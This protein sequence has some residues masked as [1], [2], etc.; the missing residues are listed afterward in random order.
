MSGYDRLENLEVQ[1]GNIKRTEQWHAEAFARATH[2]LGNVIAEHAVQRARSRYT[3][4]EYLEAEMLTLNSMLE[5]HREASARAHQEL[6]KVT[7]EYKDQIIERDY[8]E[9]TQYSRYGNSG[10]YR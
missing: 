6:A 4:L 2:Q 3:K 7:A 1:M 9:K 10:D 5:L 8:H